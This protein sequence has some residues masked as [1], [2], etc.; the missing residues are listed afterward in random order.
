MYDPGHKQILKAGR[1]MS[2]N[3]QTETSETVLNGFQMAVY[4]NC[5]QGRKKKEHKH[6]SSYYHV[7]TCW[8]LML[9]WSW[10]ETISDQS[11]VDS[12]T[13]IQNPLN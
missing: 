10:K 12:G 4:Y 1:S 3:N 2:E 6:T 11:K 5:R 8:S 9:Q 13:L 7:L